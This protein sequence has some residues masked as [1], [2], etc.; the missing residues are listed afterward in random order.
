MLLFLK[1]FTAQ[2][3]ILKLKQLFT[4]S[5]SCESP[6]VPLACISL[7]YKETWNCVPHSLQQKSDCNYLR[8]HFK[9]IPNQWRPFCEKRL[10]GSDCI[11]LQH[12]LCKFPSKKIRT[13]DR[14]NSIK[15]DLSI[16]IFDVFTFKEKIYHL[17]FCILLSFQVMI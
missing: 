2:K 17:S 16:W 1:V 12:L 6:I 3:V 7:H 11:L 5:F 4:L 15:K 13:Y 8:H 10:K 9:G 14:N